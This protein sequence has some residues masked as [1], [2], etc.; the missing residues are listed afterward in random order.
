MTSA[1]DAR[2]P[3]CHA[4]SDARR[5][6]CA[7]LGRPAGRPRQEATPRTGPPR[8]GHRARLLSRGDPGDARVRAWPGGKPYLRN[9][10]LEF[11]L[12]HSERVA[13][14]G[15]SRS[16]ALG[17]DVQGPHPNT[18]KPW[19]ARRICSPREYEHFGG[20]PGADDL[21]R[22]WARKEAVIKARARAP[23][24]PS[25]RSTCS[26][27]RSTAAGYATTSSSR[28][29]PASTRPWRSATGRELRAQPPGPVVTVR[30]FEWR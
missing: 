26:T 27:L 24:W 29:G 7:R 4:D 21:L 23:M 8:R 5:A 14:V 9:Q 22:L 12:S 20:A 11:N 19:F 13:L 10:P 15:V 25:A 30:D 28:R 2:T 1:V 6:R 17:V 3:R 16:L 18:G